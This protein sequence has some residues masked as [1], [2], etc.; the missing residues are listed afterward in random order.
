[1]KLTYE[2]IAQMAHENNRAYCHAMGDYSQAAWAFLPEE[3]R[4]S[5]IDGVTFHINNPD[6]SPE[7]SHENWWKFKRLNGWVY[8]PVKDFD[9]KE[10]PCCVPYKDLPLEQRVKDFLFAAIVDTLRM[11]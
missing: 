3:I 4:Q 2:Q 7:Q 9:K 6:S 10:H 8:G 5:A 11:F 1:M